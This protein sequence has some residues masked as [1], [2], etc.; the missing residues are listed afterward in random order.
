MS[1]EHWKREK[2]FRAQDKSYPRDPEGFPFKFLLERLREETNELEEALIN[3]TGFEDMRMVN[4][5]TRSQTEEVIKECADV[6]NFV[7]FI[8]SKALMCWPDKY[9]SETEAEAP[10]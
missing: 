1:L 2:N 6:S 3:E 8:A 5:Y 9:T 4:F 10:R 7:D